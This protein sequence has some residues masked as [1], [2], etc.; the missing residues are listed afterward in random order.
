MKSTQ[1]LTA[2]AIRKELKKAFPE[3]KFS[4]T[5]DSGA[6]T[7]SVRIEWTEGV[8]V[9][10]VDAIV[11][12][13]KY[14]SFNGMIDM[15]ENTNYRDDIPQVKFITTTRNR[16]ATTIANAIEYINKRYGLKIKYEIRKSDWSDNDWI[17]IETSWLDNQ[18]SWSQQFVY[19]EMNEMGI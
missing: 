7:S 13:Y 14:G 19:R 3:Q 12:K 6:M 9:K 5:S 11:N 15:Y 8:Q 10:D 18:N 2:R 4:V 1:A 17:D 16:K